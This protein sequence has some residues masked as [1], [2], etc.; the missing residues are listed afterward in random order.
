M[1][2]LF[3]Q[4][5]IYYRTRDPLTW[6]LLSPPHVYAMLNTIAESWW[7]ESLS[8]CLVY[9]RC[10][11]ALPSFPYKQLCSCHP[12]SAQKASYQW[13][14]PCPPYPTTTSSLLCFILLCGYLASSESFP[15]CLSED[16]QK[17][18]SLGAG[19]LSHSQLYHLEHCLTNSRS[20]RIVSE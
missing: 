11:T 6:T 14:C 9:S 10:P 8:V 5:D 19:T 15:I 13:G 2:K 1:I 16:N 3:F 20:S 4:A 18:S 7:L 17:A 12:I